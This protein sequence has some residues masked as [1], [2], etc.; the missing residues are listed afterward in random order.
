[1]WITTF[2]CQEQ[3]DYDADSELSD[4]SETFDVCMFSKFLTG[5][6]ISGDKQLSLNLVSFGRSLLQKS[7]SNL[8]RS[9]HSP[10]SVY[11]TKSHHALSVIVIWPCT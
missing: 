6:K 10:F 3:S 8:I 1:M 5:H 2:L 9:T 11:T 7:P 4:S